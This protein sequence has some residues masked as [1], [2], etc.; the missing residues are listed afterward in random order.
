MMRSK[1]LHRAET[2]LEDS[3]GIFLYW[4]KLSGESKFDKD[5]SEQVVQI[6][7]F[8]FPLTY[9]LPF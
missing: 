1:L 4:G 5:L 2:L 9:R 8:T 3:R 7:L 6:L